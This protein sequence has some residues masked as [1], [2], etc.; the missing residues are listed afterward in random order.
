MNEEKILCECGGSFYEIEFKKHFKKCIKL[1]EKYKNFDF[2][3]TQLFKEY[4]DSRES[5][6]IIK[7]FLKRFIKLFD[8]KLK[9]QFNNKNIISLSENEI[10]NESQN[11]FKASPNNLSFDTMKNILNKIINKNEKTSENINEKDTT[12]TLGKDNKDY[13]QENKLVNKHLDNYDIQNKN[14]SPNFFR[15]NSSSINSFNNLN[16]FNNNIKK[17]NNKEITIKFCYKNTQILYSEKSNLNE[18]LSSAIERF[19]KNSCPDIYKKFL[20]N[21]T[22]NGET[23]DPEKTLNEIGIKDED[24]IIFQKI[25]KNNKNNVNHNI[26]NNLNNSINSN[27]NN[28]INSNNNINNKINN[29]INNYINN[30]NI[31]NNNINNIIIND[32]N[33]KNYKIKNPKIEIINISPKIMKNNFEF[34]NNNKNLFRNNS[35]I[36][37]DKFEPIQIINNNRTEDDKEIHKHNLAYCITNFPWS[38][39]ICEKINNN[40][41]PRYYCSICDFNICFSCY[42]KRKLGYIQK[43][44][45]HKIIFQNTLLGFITHK[46]THEHSLVYCSRYVPADIATGWS[47]NVC[48]NSFSYEEWSFYCTECDYDICSNCIKK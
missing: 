18:K 9:Q 24:I 39:N 15:A 10:K 45:F 31:N 17:N 2:K 32:N 19:K 6:I 8:Y 25:K 3:M 21:P 46:S 48:R 34:N 42:S 41:I 30:N 14:K 44:E 1:L 28:N 23:I 4:L 35:S 22:Y 20:S 12:L 13:K 11:I 7:F 40:N 27:I 38:C 26:N 5:L 29:N 33:N 16:D 47:C 36:F 37:L 43:P